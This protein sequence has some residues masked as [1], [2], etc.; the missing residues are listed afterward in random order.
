LAALSGAPITV[1]GQGLAVRDWLHVADFSAGIVALLKRWKSGE[2]LHFAGR[3]P[4]QNRE[5]AQLVARLAGGGTLSFIADRQGQD[6]RYAL[7]DAAT[8]DGLGWVPEIPF[9]QGLRDTLDWYRVHGD[10]WS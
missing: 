10:L 3:M 2:T 6:A 1:H 7:D 5:V 9:E 4:R 8:R